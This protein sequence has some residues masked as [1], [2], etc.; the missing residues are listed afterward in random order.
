MFSDRQKPTPRLK[1]GPSKLSFLFIHTV[2][3]KI[4]FV[5]IWK[6]LFSISYVNWDDIVRTLI[7][8][9]PSFH[10]R[11]VVPVLPHPTNHP[12]RHRRMSITGEVCMTRQV[13]LRQRCSGIAH[14][15]IVTHHPPAV[16][17]ALKT[18]GLALVSRAVAF[19]PAANR[20]EAPTGST[21]VYKKHPGVL[22]Q[23]FNILR[24]KQEVNFKIGGIG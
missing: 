23:I 14:L 12:A 6:H 3:S 16:P 8:N 7:S 5:I 19:S 20:R 9:R 24:K 15:L 22:L 13:L 2:K 1:S 11:T 18:R 21:P 4:P 17:F 10:V